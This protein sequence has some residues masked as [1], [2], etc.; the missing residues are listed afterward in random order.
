MP[1]ELIAKWHGH[2]DLPTTFEHYVFGLSAVQAR[3]LR[4]FLSREEN[5]VWVA[6]TDAVQLMGATK[7]A[8]YKRYSPKNPRVRV[9]DSPDAPGLI[10]KRSGKPRYINVEDLAQHIRCRVHPDQSP[11]LE[12]RFPLS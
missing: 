1:S 10:L 8:V 6:I 5:Q 2:E 12:A 9:I 4:L 3:D 11:V 7:V